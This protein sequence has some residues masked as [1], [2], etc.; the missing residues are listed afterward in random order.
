MTCPLPIRFLTA[1]LLFSFFSEAQHDHPKAPLEKISPRDTVKE[2]VR[3]KQQEEAM[4]EPVMKSLYSLYLPMNF[5]GSGS[6]WQPEEN[7]MAMFSRFTAKTQYSFTGS[8][9]LRYTHQDLFDAG[10]RGDKE[11]NSANWFMGMVRHQLSERDIISGMAM[12][13]FEPLTIGDKGSPLLLQTGESNNGEPLIDHQHPHDLWMGLGAVYTHSFGRDAEVSATVGYPYEPALGPSAFMHR[14]SA[15]LL[16][17]APLSHHWQDATHISYGVG[18]LGFRLRRLKFEWSVFN[19][20]EPDENRYDFDDLRLD[21]YSFRFTWNP[22]H[23]LS[24]Q[25]SRGHL[26]SP[27]ELHPEEDVTRTTFSV[28]HTREMKK[29][30]FIASSLVVGVNHSTESPRT[31]SLLLESVLS[32]KPLALTGRYEFIQKDALELAIRTEP[33]SV[34]DSHVFT[35]GL[36]RHLNNTGPVVFR[37]GVQGSYYL[38]DERLDPIYG[39]DPFS[40]VVF[41]HVM[42]AMMFH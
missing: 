3:E 11:F 38:L 6:G 40:G 41:L 8:V 16:P 34:Y 30:T 27:E 37:A 4:M 28:M 23:T 24:M 29:Q 15:F 1:F 2:G 19:G 20:R 7:P 14:L 31:R 25:I 42:P 9:F 13:S 18:T 12:V 26:E 39:K 21:S 32:L 33:R 22:V 5:D 10:D 35:L 36:S 17:E